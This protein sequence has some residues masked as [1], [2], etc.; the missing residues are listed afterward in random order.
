MYCFGGNHRY[1]LV[2]RLG[3]NIGGNLWDNL[4]GNVGG[5]LGATL[6]E[7]LDANFGQK[8]SLIFFGD[9]NLE[10]IDDFH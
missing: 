1:S 3:G 4:G 6:G 8:K 5:N 10:Q 9:S 2:G 7:T